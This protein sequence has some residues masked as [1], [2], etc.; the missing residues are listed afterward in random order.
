MDGVYG[1]PESAHRLQPRYEDDRIRGI[2]SEGLRTAARREL[3]ESLKTMADEKLPHPLENLRRTTLDAASWFAERE[4]RGAARAKMEG[5]FAAAAVVLPVSTS[6]PIAEPCVEMYE[7]MSAA[8]RSAVAGVEVLDRLKTE[9]DPHLVA[10]LKRYVEDT[11]QALKE[12]DNRLKQLHSGLNLLFPEISSWKELIGRRDVIAHQILTLDDDKIR[13][14]A[15]RDFRAL[16]RLLGNIHFAPTIIDLERGI[17]PQ[18][19]VRANYLRGLA[20]SEPGQD[21]FVLG[22]SMVVVCLDA[23]KG[24]IVF[25]LGRSSD[26]RALM[27]VSHPGEYT[28]TVYEANSPGGDAPTD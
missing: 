25:R 15:D 17:G 18:V 5:M 21:A 22:G 12:V 6:R 2:A 4:R 27:A 24:I 20:S 3:E 8:A 1:T 28:F 19:I 23:S 26:N 13:E 11:G 10:A 16:C 9:D 7:F 14:E